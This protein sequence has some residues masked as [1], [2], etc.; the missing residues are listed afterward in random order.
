MEEV[1][2]G[3]R[4]LH[5]AGQLRAKQIDLPIVENLNSSEISLLVEPGDL[6]LGKPEFL[7]LLLGLGLLE[8][9]ADWC[10]RCRQVHGRHIPLGPSAYRIL[11]LRPPERLQRITRALQLEHK[12]LGSFVAAL[13]APKSGNLILQRVISVRRLARVSIA[14]STFDCFR[15]RDIDIVRGGELQGILPIGNLVVVERECSFSI[16]AMHRR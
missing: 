11:L 10:V 7:P 5:Q 9:V 2:G 12:R 15:F 1:V 6:F 4:F 13:Y 14:G 16:A 8:K 3:M